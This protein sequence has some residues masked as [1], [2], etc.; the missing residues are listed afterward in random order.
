MTLC[1]DYSCP[2]MEMELNSD[3]LAPQGLARERLEIE[4]K[5]ISM[6]GGRDHRCWANNFNYK[7]T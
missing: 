1:F 5:W 6:R 4:T 2:L 7:I 3:S